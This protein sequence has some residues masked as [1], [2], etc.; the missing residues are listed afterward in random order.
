MNRRE[1][2]V[3]VW[4]GGW[5]MLG[6]I[7]DWGPG[8][9]SRPSVPRLVCVSRAALCSSARH[10]ARAEAAR[11]AGGES[12]SPRTS[13]TGGC[14]AQH[15]PRLA[16]CSSPLLGRTGGM[17]AWCR[18]AEG[19]A[20]QLLASQTKKAGAA[21]GWEGWTAAQ[22]RGE[23]GNECQGSLAVFKRKEV[24]FRMIHPCTEWWGSGSPYPP[25][26]NA[27]LA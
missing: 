21:S 2:L 15:S 26:E 23:W 19:A 5:I 7:Q 22:R 24:Y 17:K 4:G 6:F 11:A 18:A 8:G 20:V 27:F 9:Q 25:K 13:G 3:C 12:W 1:V 10:Q 14:L 16:P